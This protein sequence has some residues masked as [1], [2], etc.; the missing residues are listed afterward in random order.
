MIER[1]KKMKDKKKIELAINTLGKI[2]QEVLKIGR[3]A[4]EAEQI[5]NLCEFA[6]KTLKDEPV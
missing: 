6:L 5:K 3:Y 4:Y 2:E 1:E